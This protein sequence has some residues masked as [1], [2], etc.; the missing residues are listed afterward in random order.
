MLHAMDRAT[1]ETHPHEVAQ[2]GLSGLAELAAHALGAPV[3]LLFLVAGSSL[4]LVAWF[5]AEGRLVQQAATCCRHVLDARHLSG[6]SELE[7]PELAFCAAA[8]ILS[9]SQRPIGVICVADEQ[10][11]PGLEASARRSL[12]LCARQAAAL[13]P[14]NWTAREPHDANE[15]RLRTL[16]DAMAE[17]V[18]LQDESGAVVASNAAAERILSATRETLTRQNANGPP[19]APLIRR[20]GTRMP[21]E[22]RPAVRVLR[23]GGMVNDC[24]M[25]LQAP[26]RQ[27]QW[28]S[29]NAAAIQGPR[30]ER[31]TGAVV[32]FRDITEHVRM[33]EKVAESEA[34]FRALFNSVPVGICVSHGRT[35]RYVN[36]AL[37]QMLGYDSEAELVGHETLMVVHPNSMTA[38]E[39]RYARMATG[40]YPE[41]GLIECRQRDGQ[42]ITVKVS[43]MAATFEGKPATIAIIQDVSEQYAT[44]QALLKSEANF[45]TLSQRASVGIGVRVGRI[46][47]YAN[48]ALVRLY[49]FDFEH[50]LVGRDAAD[51]VTPESRQVLVDRVRMLEREESIA[52]QI[53]RFARRDGVQVDLEVDSV[54]IEFG[55]RRATMS[56]IR[57]VTELRRAHDER[58]QAHRALLESF[59]Q[60][61]TLLKEV[62]HRV[63]NNLQVIASVLRLGREYVNDPKSLDVF[64]DS[65]ARVHSIALIHERLYQSEDLDR[66]DLATYL[67][68]LVAEL[69]RANASPFFVDTVV[70]VDQVFLDLDRCVP[71]GLIVNELVTNA[72]K[73]AFVGNR[74]DSRCVTVSFVASGADYELRVSDNGVGLPAGQNSHESLGLLLVSNLVRQL[75]GSHSLIAANG[76]SWAIVFPI[77][78]HEDS[79]FPPSS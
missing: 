57:D 45:R 39:E 4:Q 75:R 36:R 65:I 35:M 69:R 22:E 2:G 23:S 73:H 47:V 50:E 33:S 62:H 24:V 71:V 31:P 9:E 46:I 15:L 55:G 32:T 68:G 58:D 76:T 40:V 74:G 1:E 66:V 51:F 53:M 49:G 72:F 61:V 8:P 38:I 10:P 27:T 56:L 64:N 7:S 63:K 41:P 25:G 14:A 44:E 59:T 28:I 42:S 43:S 13:L 30:D 34:S 26:G 78:A 5:G 21:D 16:F 18:V 29:A 79:E 20:D 60:K 6:P 54:N 70:T 3:G 17:G 19:L 37:V 67:R 12:A 52:P 11:R 77:H 48:P